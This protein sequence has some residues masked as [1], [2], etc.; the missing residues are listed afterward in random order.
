MKTIFDYKHVKSVSVLVLQDKTTRKIR[1]KII[2]NWSKNKFGPICTAQII[3][4]DE[5]DQPRA[6]I[7]SDRCIAKVDGYGEAFDRFSA[8]VAVALTNEDFA[9]INFN[10]EGMNSF[11]AIDFFNRYNLELVEVL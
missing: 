6:F 7:V 3:S 8:A 1:G 2:A 9:Y 5:K 11:E 10:G 4:F